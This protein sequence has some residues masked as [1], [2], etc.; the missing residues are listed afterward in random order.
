[1][2]ILSSRKTMCEEIGINTTTN[3][4]I[5]T[6]R[7]AFNLYD[8]VLKMILSYLSLREKMRLESVC[9]QWQRCIF[10]KQFVLVIDAR[11]PL[12]HNQLNQLVVSVMDDNQ[13]ERNIINKKALESLLK[14]CPSIRRIYITDCEADDDVLDIICRHCPQLKTIGFDAI[15]CKEETIM[16]F[17]AKLG[18]QLTQVFF[19]TPSMSNQLV[20]KFLSCCPKLEFTFNTDIEVFVGEEVFLPKLNDVQFVWRDGDLQHFATFVAKYKHQL[21][22]L[23]MFGM[24][25]NALVSLIAE[26]RKLKTLRIHLC[27]SHDLL[28]S[29]IKNMAKSCLHL[30][31]L[32]IFLCGVFDTNFFMVIGVFHGL[33]SLLID[34]IH[35]IFINDGTTV[36]ALS[37]CTQ[38]KEIT[39]DCELIDDSF[40]SDIHKHL[41][42]LVEMTIRSNR[43][44]DKSMKSFARLQHLNC[45]TLENS[46]KYFHKITDDGVCALVNWAPS[47]RKV[48]F[49]SMPNITKVSID[50]IVAKAKSLKT[51][52]FEYKF[53]NIEKNIFDP[54]D[55]EEQEHEQEEDEEEDLYENNNEVDEFDEANAGEA[56]L[57]QFGAN[58]NQDDDD[59]DLYVEEGIKEYINKYKDWP[60]NL[61]I[62]LKINVK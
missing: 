33:R 51:I 16:S 61:R 49:K 19:D 39:I 9:R 31:H 43:I 35:G 47:L 44:T 6:N 29:D 1:M 32:K 26:L 37:G 46:K 56:K 25:Q 55:V 15:R 8:D 12:A 38:L 34:H 20:K 52:T 27:L 53:S 62:K 59:D 17:A 36:E 48:N 40:F 57:I 41:P 30:R 42:N 22:K 23:M 14:K 54:Y 2:T 18:P 50:C 28:Y 11:K 21:T 58:G 60:P 10:Q 24:R 5:G 13:I 4:S 7:N 45:I 3:H